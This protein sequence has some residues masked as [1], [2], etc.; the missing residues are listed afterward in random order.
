MDVRGD[1]IISG[2][3]TVGDTTIGEDFSTRNLSVSGI[4]TF[5]D[6]VIFTGANSNARWDY[7]ASDLT[8]FDNKTLLCMGRFHENKSID[9]LIRAMTFLSSYSLVIVG[10]GPL[11]ELYESLIN[12]LIR[13]PNI[14]ILMINIYNTDF[15]NLFK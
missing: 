7:S 9:T 14:V 6:D 15:G 3:L 8:L 13:V 5:G 1:V 12:K 2:E 11:K 10:S 4:S